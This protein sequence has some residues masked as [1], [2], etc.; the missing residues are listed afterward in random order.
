MIAKTAAATLAFIL[1]ALLLFVGACSLWA[2]S[3]MVTL[4]DSLGMRRAA[5]AYSV[6]CYEQSGE[7]ADL[8]KAVE[9]KFSVSE[10]AE[11]FSVTARLGTELLL[12]EEYPAFCEEQDAVFSSEYYADY[13][14]YMT[15]LVALAQQLAEDTGG[16]AGA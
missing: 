14:A 3:V 15:A 11:D 2:P 5:A 13:D 4:T 16:S 8:A 6:S 9:R 7:I 1:A 10:S 12:S